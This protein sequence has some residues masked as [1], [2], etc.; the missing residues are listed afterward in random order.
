MTSTDTSTYVDEA[1]R[2][3]AVIIEQITAAERL[4]ELL[5]D[6]WDTTASESDHYAEI[7]RLAETIDLPV[8]DYDLGSDIIER[9]NDLTAEWGCGFSR[10]T[11]VRVV[12]AGGGPEG[13]IDVTVDEHKNVTAEIGYRDWFQ[14]AITTPLSDEQAQAA[15]L[16]YRI[17]LLLDSI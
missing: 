8:D 4:R 9:L 10:H 12:L 6:A 16:L 2:F 1:Q 17:D 7:I 5:D 15:Y 11:T 13:W 14:Q 3:T